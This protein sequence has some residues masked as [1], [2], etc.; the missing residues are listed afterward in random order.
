MAG[1]AWPRRA[2]LIFSDLGEGDA[3]PSGECLADEPVLA[4]EG[5]AQGNG[6]P[7]PQFGR[8]AVEQ[9][10]AGVVVAVRA[11]GFPEPGVVAVVPFGTGQAVAV[12]ADLAAS[13]GSAPQ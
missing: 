7:A 11:Q 9:D 10:R 2:P 12:R 6:E 1:S 5:A 3:D 13:A 4:G 8:G